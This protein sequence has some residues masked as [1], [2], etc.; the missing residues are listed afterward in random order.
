MRKI[1]ITIS[2]IFFCCLFA[3]KS[4]QNPKDDG[5]KNGNTD[6]DFPIILYAPEAKISYG[7]TVRKIQMG[8]QIIDGSTII[9]G[10]RK[11]YILL[12]DGQIVELSKNSRADFFIADSYIKLHT[13]TATIHIENPP[14][15]FVFR[16]WRD[17]STVRYASEK[18]MWLLFND[19]MRVFHRGEVELFHQHTSPNVKWYEN[20]S[21]DGEYLFN[22]INNREIPASDYQFDFPSLRRKLFRHYVKGHSGYATYQN[23]K[24]L[25]GG[26]LYQ[27]EFWK[28]KMVYDLWIAVSPNSGFYSEAW[29]EWNDLLSHIK[30]IQICQPDDPV[31]IRAGLLENIRFG[32][33][34][35]V[36]NYNNAIFIPFEKMT[37]LELKFR[38]DNFSASAFTDNLAY[39]RLFGLNVEG[40]TSDRMYLKFF[41]AGDWNLFAEIDDKDGDGYPDEIDPQPDNFNVPEDSIIISENLQNIDDFERHQIHGIGGGFRYNFVRYKKFRAYIAGET[42]ILNTPGA[43]ISFPNLALGIKWFHFSIGTDFQTPQFVNGVFDRNYEWEKA[44]FVT[45]TLG[46]LNL[47]SIVSELEEEKGWLYGWNY[48]FK[49]AIPKM[50]ILN[51][52][53]RD[54]YRGESRDKRF[55]ISLYNNYSFTDYILSSM[56][57]IEQNNVSKI[58]REKT[59]GE[60]WGIE[61]GFRLH[62]SIRINTRYREKFEDNNSDNF[63]GHDEVKRSFNADLIIDGTYWWHK[64]LEW[65][66]KK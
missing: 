65:V 1:I 2:I 17:S 23:D 15:T 47:V 3:E 29:D 46:N 42:A 34:I 18:K 41:Y 28:I 10:K 22:L 40:K 62:K 53:F 25:Y 36:D 54:I 16:I 33:G 24:Y 7:D 9:T 60:Q 21:K 44:R 55:H 57:F 48:A 19:S 63:I 11:A 58:L 4:I 12:F 64:F 61:F 56:I 39:P 27:I 38:K 31:F 50:A 35:L 6:R 20:S 32:N 52:R 13:G 37:G 43:G 66:R 30:Y 8:E 59:D 26:L 14:D 51:I 49:I 45:D 5:S